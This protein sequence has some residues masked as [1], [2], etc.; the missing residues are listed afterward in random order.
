MPALHRALALE[1]MHDVAVSVGEDLHFDVAR[2]IDQALDVQRAVA[3]RRQGF[4][5]RAA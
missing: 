1:Q 2:A 5:W 4:V 3:E